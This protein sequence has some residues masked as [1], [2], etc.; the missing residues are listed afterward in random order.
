MK[1][2]K[3][4]AMIGVMGLAFAA[5][6]PTL[7]DGP[8]PYAPVDATYLAE[9]ITYTQ[10]ADEACTQPDVNGNYVKFG[11]AAGIVQV[12]VEGTTGVLYTG[13]G[14]VFK[15]PAKRGQEPQMNITFRVVNADGTFTEAT[16]TFG[17][18]PPTEL[19]PELLMLA[20]DFGQ[21]VWKYSVL[22]ENVWGEA[23]H[24]GDGTEFDAP[25]EVG[26][27]WW[28]HSPDKLA[29]K[30]DYTGGQV[31][32]DQAPGAY[33]VFN[34]DGTVTTY[35]PEGEKVRSGTFKVDNYDPTRASGWE[36]GKLTTSEPAIL[37]PWS[38]CDD[39]TGPVTNFDIMHLSA[40]DMTLVFTNGV[41]AGG[42]D[43]ITY[44]C[45][46]AAT[47]DPLT[48]EG[49][50]TY[51]ANGYGN[52]GHAGDGF[53]FNTPGAVDGNW[54]GVGSGDELADQIQHAG[55]AATG[56]ESSAAYMVF[57]DNTVTT[58]APDGTK[59]R[60]GTWEVVM[61]DYA[62]GGGRPTGWELGKLTTS[63]PALLFPWMINGGGTPVTEFDIMYFDAHHMTLV[64][65][66]GAAAGD[67]GEITHWCFVRK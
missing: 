61:N 67:W 28:G 9:G 64:Y 7:I 66:N 42:W 43:R 38:I 51:D 55:G 4:I 22:N 25:G 8:E 2:I 39:Y 37:F 54:W 36:L 63:E 56:D 59:V 3:L 41:E 15:L 13:S 30:T 27:W 60:G 23:G 32:G 19:S 31:Y 21:K 65:T 1:N 14:G 35:S 12:M 16:L 29:D 48:I 44:W 57:E 26:G 18:T 34:E 10:Y 52:G 47:P 17:C 45:F 11:S 46:T 50:W 58:Y 24:A 49:A 40:Q 53:A 20:S 62:T 5:C 33:M 6:E